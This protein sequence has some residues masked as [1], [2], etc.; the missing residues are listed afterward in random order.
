MK[1][2]KIIHGFINPIQKTNGMLS[3]NKHMITHKS[4]F[5]LLI[6]F[7]L[8]TLQ[9]TFAQKFIIPVLPDT[10][11]E[12]SDNPEMFISQIN[13]IA[14]NKTLLNIPIVLHVGD[15]TN[16]QTPDQFMWKTA[17]RGFKILD[18]ARIPYAL[19][20][21]NHD[22]AAVMAGGNT[23]PGD[24]IANLRDTR[25]FNEYFPVQRF[26]SQKGRFEKNKSDNAWYTFKAGGLKWL[27]VTLEFATRQGPVD[28]ANKVIFSKPNYNVIIVTHNFLTG[29]GTIC[30]D[31]SGIGYLG[32]QSV[33]DQL[34]KIHSNILMV[35]SGHVCSSAWCDG[36]G[37]NGNHIYQM[38]QDYQA[39][40][41]GGGFIRLLEIDTKEATISA[42]MY[43]PYS[44]QT[45]TDSSL[46]SFSNV[47]FIGK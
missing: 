28:W 15:I 21:G 46:F 3:I 37:V 16:W 10:Q 6:L 39:D 40:H 14:N 1:N 33:Y 8:F 38:L 17:S 29:K 31:K 5:N 9:V 43:S 44:N 19:T 30:Q 12:M 23:A 26:K 35:V 45:K 41:S 20:L 11:Y 2:I 47:K 18:H 34:V 27:V 25:Q 36:I 42:K 22:C 32:P 7:L 24:V 13:W 4:R